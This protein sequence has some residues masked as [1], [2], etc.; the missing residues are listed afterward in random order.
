M[1]IDLVDDYQQISDNIFFVGDISLLFDSDG[2]LNDQNL[3]IQKL[4]KDLSCIR[5]M[6][7]DVDIILLEDDH[8]EL[9]SSAQSSGLFYRMSG[10]R[11][12]IAK[13][14]RDLICP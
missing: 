1:K 5:Y 14:E 9:Y 3:I 4:K 11:I 6:M 8:I 13:D 10:D 12:N 2:I 7:S